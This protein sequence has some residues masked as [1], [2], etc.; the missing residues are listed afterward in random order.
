M[1]SRIATLNTF[2]SLTTSPVSAIDF[3]SNAIT[4]GFNDSSLGWVNGIATDTGSA[5]N[6]I[7]TAPFGSPTALNAGFY[8][9]FIAA[10]ANTGNSTLTVNP[11]TSAN[12]LDWKGNPLPPGAVQA[13]ALIKAVYVAGAFRVGY[14]VNSGVV[15]SNPVVTVAG[16]TTVACGGASQVTIM[17]DTTGGPSG[18]YIL[19][20]TGILIGAHVDI[21][22]FMAGGGQKFGLQ[23]CTDSAGNAINNIRTGDWFGGSQTNNDLT[24]ALSWGATFAYFIGFCFRDSRNS[25]T[26]MKF[27]DF[28]S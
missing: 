25:L 13:G 10:N 18:N 7:V 24:V 14:N 21:H 23:G 28:Y 11:L 20:L 17:F 1:A 5:N 26:Y 16:T 12:L 2:A 6:Y 22:W 15:F 4:T 27:V 3:N 8:V 9:A 19:T